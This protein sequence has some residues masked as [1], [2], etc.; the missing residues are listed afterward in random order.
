MNEKELILGKVALRL[1]PT[2][3]LHSQEMHFPASVEWHLAR[4]RAVK[5]Q[6][7][8]TVP[9]T[10]CRFQLNRRFRGEIIGASLRFN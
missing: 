2:V 4:C 9:I 6:K 7:E 10:G 3:H 1:A 5:G 8:I